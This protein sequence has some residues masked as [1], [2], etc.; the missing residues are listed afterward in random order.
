MAG[1]EVLGWR[2]RRARAHLAAPDLGSAGPRPPWPP[3]AS[4]RPSA[5]PK[6]KHFLPP[7]SFVSLIQTEYIFYITRKKSS[8]TY[9]CDVITTK[10]TGLH[11]IDAK[12]NA[13][14][15]VG[16]KT[17]VCNHICM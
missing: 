10:L 3:A 1:Q 4:A 2:L 7:I 15:S 9:V 14:F 6:S 11:Y 13:G 17:Q 12:N 5:S 16:R 8:L